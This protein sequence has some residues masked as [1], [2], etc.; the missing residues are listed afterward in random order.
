MNILESIVTK[1][2]FAAIAPF[3]TLLSKAVFCR[4]VELR[5]QMGKSQLSKCPNLYCKPR[6]R[7]EHPNIGVLTVYFEKFNNANLSLNYIQCHSFLYISLL[8]NSPNS[9]I[10]FCGISK[11][12]VIWHPF[13][14]L[15]SR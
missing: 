7:I 10:D 12:R 14:K 3:D 9:I 2:K 6:C 15:I 5:L 8:I 13:R 1:R 4:C 11:N